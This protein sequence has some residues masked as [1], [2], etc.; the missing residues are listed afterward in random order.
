[1]EVAWPAAAG[2]TDRHKLRVALTSLRRQLEPPGVPAGVVIFSDRHTVQ[3]NPETVSTDVAEFESALQAARM[4]GRRGTRAA[5]GGGCRS[6]PGELLPGLF[7]GMDCTERQRLAQSHL[8][9]LDQ[10]IAWKEQA[11]D[12]TGAVEYARR[13]VAA[14]PLR[15]ESHQQ[16]IRLLAAAGRP[17]AAR[18]QYQELERLLARELGEAPGAATRRLVDAIEQQANPARS[19]LGRSVFGVRYSVFG[20][21]PHTER[22]T[23]NGE[24]PTPSETPLPAGTLTFL[25]VEFDH[26]PDAA[27]EALRPLFRG[28]G[29]REVPGPAG[30][31][32]VAFGRA[33]E[34]MAA[35]LAGMARASPPTSSPSREGLLAAEPEPREM[36]TPTREPPRMALDTGEV[37]PGDPPQQSPALEHGIRLLLAAHRVRSWSQTRARHCSGTL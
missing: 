16:L 26:A 12:R 31:V 25:L 24:R 1:M 14:D 4:P 7:E 19:G 9:S 15:E 6:V 34:A 10:L 29:G 17:E 13:A 2:T 5:P 20:S 11:G 28:Y 30:V 22:R 35:A 8:Q 36:P 33:S 37:E 21:E 18:Q 27:V 32:A 23:P 3:L